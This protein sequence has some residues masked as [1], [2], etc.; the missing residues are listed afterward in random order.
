MVNLGGCRGSHE[1]SVSVWESLVRLPDVGTCTLNGG[2]VFCG[3]DPGLYPS[4][5]SQ[6]SR[7]SEQAARVRLSLLLE[8]GY[9]WLT[10]GLHTQPAHSKKL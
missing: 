2:G 10:S 3:L 7:C 9:L 1:T 5:E 4:E 8:V 6:L